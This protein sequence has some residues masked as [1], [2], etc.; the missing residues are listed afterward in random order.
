ML[1]KHLKGNQFT[2][3]VMVLRNQISIGR[4]ISTC[5]RQNM[6]HGSGGA[7]HA[8][9]QRLL[10]H[11]HRL[12][13]DHWSRLIHTRGD[14]RGRQHRER[15]DRRVHGQALFLQVTG[16]VLATQRGR[17][18]VG[19]AVTAGFVER[20]RRHFA[21]ARARMLHLVSAALSAGII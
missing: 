8:L 3:R 7:R 9:F 10:G 6:T 17:V 2:K 14:R 21:D 13:L 12:E 1:Q 18:E 4:L 11:H 15:L 20:R 5:I 16:V 19:N